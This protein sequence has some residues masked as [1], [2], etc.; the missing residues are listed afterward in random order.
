MR[1]SRFLKDG[2]LSE[3]AIQQTVMDFIR[4]N[5]MLS[6]CAIHIPNEGKRTRFYGNRLKKMGMRPGVADLF[7]ALPRNGYHGAW[8][9]LKSEKGVLSEEQRL[10]LED[11]AELHYYTS[12]CYSIDEAI[13]E[14][15]AY[16]YG[17]V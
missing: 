7:I 10:F 6:K 11:M 2:S 15:S 8:I 16:V 1:T 3:D 4:T 9:E 12:V 5:P 13:E 14:I 17:R